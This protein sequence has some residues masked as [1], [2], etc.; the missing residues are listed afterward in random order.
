MPICVPRYRSRQVDTLA[1]LHLAHQCMLS[2]HKHS[3][4]AGINPYGTFYEV[5]G[6]AQDAS[7]PL[8][9]FQKPNT[10]GFFTAADLRE[11]EPFGYTYTP[12]QVWGGLQ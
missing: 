5:P 12:I 9:P 10:T 3:L 7:T 8:P 6:T 2:P 4:T 1:P 11:T